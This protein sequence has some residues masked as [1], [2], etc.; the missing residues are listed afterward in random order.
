MNELK[1]LA[2][3]ERS[4]NVV[5]LGSP[6]LEETFAVGLQ[7]KRLRVVIPHIF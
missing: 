6:E 4:E 1:M 3:V 5:F 7:L 2:F